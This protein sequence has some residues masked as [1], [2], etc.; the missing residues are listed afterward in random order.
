MV[1][2]EVYRQLA[3]LRRELPELTDPDLRQIDVHVDEEA[4]TL[5]MRRG[6]VSVVVNVGG[7]AADI[8]LSG[9]HEVLFTTPA[10]ASLVADGL[11][12]PPHAGALVRRT[13]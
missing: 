6:A 1:L 11:T 8:E 13:R 7:A 5:V 10:G 4:R 2:L 9:E 12:L 3:A